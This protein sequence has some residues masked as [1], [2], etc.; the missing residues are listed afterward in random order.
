MEEGEKGTTL[1]TS[2]GKDWLRLPSGRNAN[3][4]GEA[5]LPLTEYRNKTSMQKIRLKGRWK[6]A[7]ICVNCPNQAHFASLAAQTLAPHS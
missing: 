6:E 1:H 7:E 2:K 4:S 5:R 3:S